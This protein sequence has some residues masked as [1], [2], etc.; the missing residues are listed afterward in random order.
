MITRLRMF[1]GN[2]S[3]YLLVDDRYPKLKKLEREWYY[4]YSTDS[5]YSRFPKMLEEYM[6]W[7]DKQQEYLPL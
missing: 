4:Y 3:I 6:D 7:Y 1:V 2:R 5:L